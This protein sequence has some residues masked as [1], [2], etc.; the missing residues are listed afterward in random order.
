[1][2][3]QSSETMNSKVVWVEEG[4]MGMYQP[5][6]NNRGKFSQG[7]DPGKSKKNNNVSWNHFIEKT[8]LHGIKHVFHKESSKLKRFAQLVSYSS[9]GLADAHF[10]SCHI[11]RI[12]RVKTLFLYIL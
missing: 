11:K 7:T 8:T 4:T 10:V 1:M 5:A 2:L 9:I 6:V 3:K 12:T